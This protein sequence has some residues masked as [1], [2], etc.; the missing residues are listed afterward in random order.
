[1][2]DMI[3]NASRG[4]LRRQATRPVILAITS[5]G[6]DYSSRGYETV[7]RAVE[8]SGAT[9]H[10]I[11]FTS[12]GASLATDAHYRDMVLNRGTERTGGERHDLLQGQRLIEM[13]HAVAAE[14]VNQ[15]DV[16]YARPDMLVPPDRIDV[17]LTGE[18]LVARGTLVTQRDD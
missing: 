10:A 16:V 7:L 18:A 1:M 2:L 5:E 11:V 17:E 14:L 9:L 12:S 13:L 3:Y 8:D 6:P 15:Y 4:L